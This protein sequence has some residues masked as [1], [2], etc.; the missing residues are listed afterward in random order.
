M[1]CKAAETVDLEDIVKKWAVQMYDMTKSKEQAR[2]PKDHLVFNFNWKRIKFVH[3]EPEFHNPSK[4]T[5]PKSQIL[6]RTNFTNTTDQ[7]QEYSFKTERTTCS[8]C[9]VNFERT[10]TIGMEMNLSLKTPCEIF[11]ANAGFKRELSVTNAQGQCIEESLSW[12]VDSQIKVPAR[13][14]TSAELVVKEDEY[15]GPFTIRTEIAGKMLVSVTNGRDN[16]SFLKSIEGDI[17]E[18]IKPETENGFKGFTRENKVISFV[19]KGSCHFRYGIE[20]NVTVSQQ[21]LENIN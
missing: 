20:Q 7:D 21:S 12:G 9:E 14:R 17:S 19:T 18:I 3:H 10:I 4:P 6:F 11:E 15:G 2:I 16:N 5:Q 8:V 13:T 1:T